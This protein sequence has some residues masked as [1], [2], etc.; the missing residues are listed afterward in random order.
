MQYV[1]KCKF[2][3]DGDFLIIVPIET[4][5]SFRRMKKLVQD[6][7]VIAAALRTSPNLVIFCFS[8][9]SGTFEFPM[10]VSSAFA[11]AMSWLNM[12]RLSV[13]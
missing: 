2:S 10:F 6:L 8:F 4:I 3:S 1:F 13:H 9:C 7:S 11:I 12:F 5:A